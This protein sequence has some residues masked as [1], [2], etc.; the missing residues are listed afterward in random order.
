VKVKQPEASAVKRGKPAAASEKA[1]LEKRIA[2]VEAELAAL[3]E[4]LQQES[5]TLTPAEL[6]EL[7]EKREVVQGQ[8]DALYEQWVLVE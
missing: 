2:A 7:W 8:L 3:D 1:A 5:E 6:V 4:R